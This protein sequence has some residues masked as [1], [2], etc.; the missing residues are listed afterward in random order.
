MPTSTPKAVE[1][2]QQLLRWMIPQVE[3]FPR[4]HRFT[5]GERIEG[6]LLDVLE[7]LVLLE[8]K[9]SICSINILLLFVFVILSVISF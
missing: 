3:K 8:Q 5:L 7:A 1:D 9:R 2:C 4:S 6:G